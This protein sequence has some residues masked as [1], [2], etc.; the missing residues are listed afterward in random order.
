MKITKQNIDKLNYE[1]KDDFYW[2]DELKGFGVKVTKNKKNYIVQS[3]AN[4]RSIRKN[5]ASCNV[6]TP[7]EARKE[8]KVLL[9]LMAKNVD[10][11]A[12]ER[13]NTLKSVTLEQA[14]ED[15][16]SLRNLT[17]KTATDYQRAMETTF[18]EWKNRNIVAID[19]E[20]IEKKFRDKS[21]C[22]PALANLHFRFLRALL[23]F[24]MEK[25]STNGE[26]LIPSNP[27]TRLTILKMWNR[28]ERRTTFVNPH[29]I[30][31]FFK[32]LQVKNTDR[33]QVKIAKKQCMFVLFTGCREQ[34]AA[35]L[36]RCDINF[37]NKT[38]TFMVTKNHKK[39]TL[40]YGVWFEKF[41]NELC[42]NLK[43]NDFLFPSN[44]K[45]G[46]IKDHRKAI[47]EIS[48][49]CEVPFRL[50]DLRRTF[51]SI[52]NHHLT[53]SY[54]PYVIKRLLNHSEKDVTAGYIQYDIEDL[55]QPMQM[56]EDYIL[57]QAKVKKV[58]KESEE[59]KNN[60]N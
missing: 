29:Q 28:V 50:Q 46:H 23:N 52:V 51:A 15:Y 55:R 19:R 57:V 45:T 42:N 21:S 26:P 41:L 7:D 18:F 37:D 22:A 39:H 43:S 12:E 8:A 34:E 3:R 33:E 4:G 2:D 59:E 30:E 49:E 14:F 35:R 58:E 48:E 56:I 5:I 17:E 38:F 32:G 24:A 27:C 11:V 13:R 40:P 60:E 36:R 54:S 9:G 53:K 31:N 1:G 16:K 10:I 44:N 6:L 47:K 20:M 25:Y